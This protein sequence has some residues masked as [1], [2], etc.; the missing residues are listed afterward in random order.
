MNRFKTHRLTKPVG[1][2]VP[3]LLRHK[4]PTPL[5]PATMLLLAKALQ[6]RQAGKPVLYY[7]ATDKVADI[8][9]VY[10]LPD[11]RSAAG[12]DI[13][14]HGVR[15]TRAVRATLDSAA[16]QAV[17]RRAALSRAVDQVGMLSTL[18]GQLQQLQAQ[19]TERQTALQKAEALRD[20]LVGNPFGHQAGDFAFAWCQPFKDRLGGR[21]RF[22]RRCLT[23]QQE[24]LR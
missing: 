3:A 5:T 4:Q 15:D 11:D 6:Q 17:A 2:K 1:L 12:F 19:M 18:R 24:H 14:A 20:D 16:A 21:R 13:S 23:Q 8:T 7:I 10:R 22:W 9:Q